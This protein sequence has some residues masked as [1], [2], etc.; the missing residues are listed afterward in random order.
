MAHLAILG[1]GVV[2]FATGQ[3]FALHGHRITYID[4]DLGKVRQLRSEG[5]DARVP[6]AFDYASADATMVC[7]STPTIDGAPVLDRLIDAVTGLARGLASA[8]RRHVIV[9]RS[10]ALPTTTEK[11]LKP[12]IE[13]ESGRR[14]GEDL[15][16]C[17]NPEF[18]R[19]TSAVEDFASP[20]LT[21]LGCERDED[22]R[23]L[24]E[25]YAP[26]GGEIVRTDWTTAEV[27]K[28]AN[29]L[30]NATKISFFNEF[31]LFCERLG[32]DG[33]PVG[34]V[35]SMSAEGM[36]NPRYGTRAGW[37]YGGACLEKDTKG[38]L[39]LARR[40]DIPMPLLAATVEVNEA[41]IARGGP[42]PAAL[43]E[44]VPD[45]EV[46]QPRGT[47]RIPVPMFTPDTAAAAGNGRSSAVT[48]RGLRTVPLS[49]P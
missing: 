4:C 47:R 9:V 8:E 34:R 6:G 36:W 29:N 33:E 3:G 46:V 22:Y 21:L 15:G 31:H 45:L 19:Q 20:W 18:L 1:A 23:F 32:I 39:A 14:V 27:I 7:V 30:Y 17:V 37:P 42:V 44:V 12:L 43:A 49:E 40:M 26:F 11:V 41:M 24:S 13:R 10:T 35:V 38:L 2:G 16:L 48:A 5:Y 28:Y 25:L